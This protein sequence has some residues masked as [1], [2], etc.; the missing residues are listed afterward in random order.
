MPLRILV[1]DD[2][3]V[4]RQG[5]RLILRDRPDWQICGEAE[6]GAEALQKETQLHPDLIILDVTM[7]DI[8]G[9]Q[10]ASELRSRNSPAKIIILTMHEAKELEHAV[11]AAGAQGYVIK[12]HAARDLVTAIQTV[13]DGGHFF[14]FGDTPSKGRKGLQ[15]PVSVPS[16]TDPSETIKETICEYYWAEFWHEQPE[17]TIPDVVRAL[18]PCLRGLVA[19]NT[20]WDSGTLDSPNRILGQDWSMIGRHAISPLITDTTTGQW[21]RSS[22]GWDEWYFFRPPAPDVVLRPICNYQGLSLGQWRQLCFPDGVDLREQL[23]R[24]RP[25]VV[26]GE[27]D[28][29]FILARDPV[30]VKHFSGLAREV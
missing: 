28:K 24:A 27:G 17:L 29:V 26:L 3:D 20:S 14:T 9:L 4:V 15:K 11:K 21:P 23:D 5:V 10:V 13:I 18:A 2:H 1:V 30:T 7:P 12:T 19:L 22:C 6:N 16:D 25:E 8:G